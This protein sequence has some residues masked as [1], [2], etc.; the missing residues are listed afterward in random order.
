MGKVP[1]A[2]RIGVS[3]IAFA[4]SAVLTA[5]P[6]LVSESPGTN[7][8]LTLKAIKSAQSTLWIN[9]YELNSTTI[10]E[11]IVE[12]IKA[13]VKVD[14]L[15]EGQPVGG[16][17]KTS[18]EA[19][20]SIMAAMGKK[21]GNN[22][23]IMSAS[24]TSAR[25][26]HFDHAKYILVDDQQ[27]L[28]GS[29]NYS[30]TGNPKEG[31]KGNRGWEVLTEEAAISNRFHQ[32]FKSD[33]DTSKGDVKK[34]TGTLVGINL[35]EELVFPEDENGRAK[36]KP[37]QGIQGIDADKIE[38]ITSPDNSE[39]GILALIDSAK[40]SLDVE[41]MSFNS[42]WKD[43]K[44]PFYDALIRAAKRG[45]EVRVLLNDSTVFGGGSSASNPNLDTVKA[46]NKVGG[47][48]GSLKAKIA[49]IEQMGVTY[50]H[51]KGVL[52]DG[53]KALVSSI[54][55]TENSVVNN[56]EAA[57]LITSTDVY[58]HYERLFEKDWSVS[59]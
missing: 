44:S 39:K 5:S 38:I 2:N 27:L 16:Y 19:R 40:S 45:V 33:T 32:I 29:E 4:L 49:D 36:K 51:N 9:A 58:D 55:W 7:L 6:I 47:I 42:N 34:Y 31:K 57:L 24:S 15:E 52:V 13:G 1:V 37:G 54:N 25:R 35:V 20:S 11:A 8:Q 48:K 12:Q 22:F 53:N 41:Q 30:D 28:L 26:F 46:L 17:T 3:L 14:I 50:I 23:Y 21:K 18:K 10:T 56:R 59:R 43:K